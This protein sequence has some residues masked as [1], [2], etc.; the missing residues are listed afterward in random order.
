ML[1]V[2]FEH[3]VGFA[4]F[5]V[6]EF[7]EVGTFLPQVEQSVTD[8]ARFNKVVKLTSFVSFSTAVDALEAINAISEGI[9]MFYLTFVLFT[10]DS[11]LVIAL[12]FSIF[13]SVLGIAPDTLVAFLEN[14]FPK[15]KKSKHS[16]GVLDPKL[17]ANIHETTGIQC[18]S[19]GVIP[20]ITRGL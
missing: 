14:N 5:E 9:T 8:L 17:G 3:S 16:L 11:Y 20:E 12:K 19:T 18:I 6:I 13:I 4:L 2:L 1:F 10:K 7:E 15:K